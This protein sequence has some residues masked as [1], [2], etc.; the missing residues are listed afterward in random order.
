MHALIE[1]STH[2]HQHQINIVFANHS[3][4]DVIG[5]KKLVIKYFLEEMVSSANLKVRINVILGLSHQF[6][7]MGQSAFNM[8]Q[9][10]ND[11]TLGESHLLLNN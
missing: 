10:Q 9:N 7:Q 2:T 1:E 8:E 4:E 6:I 11:S 3:E 5:T